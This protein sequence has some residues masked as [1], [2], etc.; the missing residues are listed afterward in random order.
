MADGGESS[1]VMTQAKLR[2]LVVDDHPLFRQGVCLFLKSIPE[3][4]LVKEAGNGRDALRVLE[5]EEVIHLVLVDLQMP[6]MDGVQLTRKIKTLYPEVKVLV[7]TSFSGWEK[8]YPSLQAGADGYLLKDAG[9]DQL[10]GAIQAVIAGGHYFEPE[11]TTKILSELNRE[12]RD[13]GE[14]PPEDSSYKELSQREIDVLKLIA[15]GLGN[16]EITEKLF[17]SEKTVKTHVAN[18]LG[19][20]Q[21]RSRTQAAL[22]ATK[23]GWFN[24]NQEQKR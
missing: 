14:K 6:V 24:L 21:V 2:V 5:K 16:R 18:I 20:L 23:M 12:K 22:Y 3:I 11:V 8:V 13:T 9:P 10:Y 19:K 4:T 7:L 15:A 17:I 1:M